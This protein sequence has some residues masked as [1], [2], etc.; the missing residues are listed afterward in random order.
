MATLAFR[1]HKSR[2]EEFI[3]V[4]EMLGGENKLKLNGSDETLIYFIDDS[5]LLALKIEEAK[6][7]EFMV[8]TLEE[9]LEKYPYKVG[10]KVLCC[11]IETIIKNI[12]WDSSVGEMIYFMDIL[13]VTKGV[14]MKDLQPYKEQE[15]ENLTISNEEAEKHKIQIPE[16]P[17]SINLSQTNVN[18]IEVVLGDYEFTLKDGK[19]YFVKKKPKYPKDYEECCEV[20]GISD[21]RGFGFINLSECE[22][23]LM[24]SFIQ[25]KRCCNAYW[26]IAGEELG[27]DKPWEPDWNDC[28]QRKFGLYTLENEIRCINLQVLKNIILVF[29][30]EEIRDTFYEN[31]K[32]LINQC[33][34]LL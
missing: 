23:I 27:L 15:I 1:G 20:L 16:F 19:T 33:K 14:Y 5:F 22:N 28:A 6:L 21:N 2:G 13:G 10:G 4:L 11:G 8:F 26:K 3:Q 30:T 31:F 24:S 9:F 7:S 25:L 12:D 34:E 17:Q 18:E 32:D 29:P